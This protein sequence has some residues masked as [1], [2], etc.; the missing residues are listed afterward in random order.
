MN[1][2]IT[3][4]NI[5]E[6][7]DN[8][9]SVTN[10]F[11]QTH[12]N[13]KNEL[14]LFSLPEVTN[15][16]LNI[17][18]AHLRRVLKN[19]PKLPQGT[20]SVPGGIRWFSFY[21]IMELRNYFHSEGS[22]QKNYLPYRPSHKPAKII[23]IA[24]FCGQTGKTTTTA[25]LASASAMNGYRVLLID[26][27]PHSELTKCFT[28]DPSINLKTSFEIFPYHYAKH[29]QT[30]NKI[31]IQRGENITPLPQNIIEAQE[32]SVNNTQINT[33]WDTIKIIPSTFDDIETNINI[34]KWIGES[35]NWK[36]WQSLND[37]LMN[38]DILNNYDIVMIDTASS[39]SFAS[40]S[41]LYCADI[42]FIPCPMEKEK[43]KRTEVSLSQ[44]HAVMYSIEE[45][46]KINA[47]SI[48]ETAQ[49]LSWDCIKIIPISKIKDSRHPIDLFNQLKVKSP[50]SMFN[51]PMPYIPF[52]CEN[53]KNVRKN[54][55]EIDY[56]DV[57]KSEHEQTRRQLDT[58]YNEFQSTIITAWNT[59]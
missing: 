14:R 15:T 8:Y 53:D 35:P 30:I 2:V 52:I 25:H 49:P 26:L 16:L 4:K 27:D 6:I 17:A 3:T 37:C 38:N 33:L 56:R 1:N 12:S 41:A 24:N 43:I 22:K 23:T 59:T 11:T 20:A 46:E 58:L 40:I 28:S 54:F 21:E 18:P 51:N 55:Y 7:A 31:K 10:A 29:L 9:A 44:L 13:G 19:N 45:L 50:N 48:G 39:F 42:V 36:Y 32:F 34:A 57:N 5:R 47:T